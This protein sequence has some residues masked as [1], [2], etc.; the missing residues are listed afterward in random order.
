[1]C[2]I[3]QPIIKKEP[4]SF[5]SGTEVILKRVYFFH[6]KIKKQNRDSSPISL[7]PGPHTRQRQRKNK[8][9][10]QQIQVKSE[11]VWDPPFV[12]SSPCSFQTA[13]CD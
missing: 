13:V 4:F 8:P 1:M 11:L 9:G 10:Y 6:E 12:A 3:Y 7:P 5:I 2:S